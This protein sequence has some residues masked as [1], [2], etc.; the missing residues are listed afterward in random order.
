[1]T[2]IIFAAL[3]FLC[4]QLLISAPVVSAVVEYHETAPE[5]SPPYQAPAPVEF[6]TVYPVALDTDLQRY[7]VD[8]CE[9]RHVPPEIVLAIIER[10]SDCQA[11]AI[12]DGGKSYGL[13][14]IRQDIHRDRCIALNAPCLLDPMQN[15]RVG[16][17]YLAEL[18]SWG[19]GIAW[20][21]SFYNGHGG[22]PCDYATEVMARAE[23][24][25]ESVMIVEG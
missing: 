23:V 12:G 24:L 14:Q 4:L 21:L 6:Y 25:A 7:I 18:L 5:V 3:F 8:I 13:M 20:A 9:E 17:D 22:A 2:R 19:H 15:V 16:V 1:M 10:E 11:D